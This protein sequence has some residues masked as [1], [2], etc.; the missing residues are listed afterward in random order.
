M[1]LKLEVC[2]MALRY[3]DNYFCF[4]PSLMIEVQVEGLR[5]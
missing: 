2:K 4:E 3:T 5:A 1:M